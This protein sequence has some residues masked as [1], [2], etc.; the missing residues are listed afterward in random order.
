MTWARVVENEIIEIFEED[1]A[2]Y[3]HPDVL[4]EWVDIPNEGVHVGWKF[5]NGQ[6]ISGGQWYDEFRAE[7]PLPP[8]GPPTVQIEVNHKETRTHDQFE[9]NYMIGG[10]GE[11]VEWNINGVKYTD[12]KVTLELAKTSE[13]F[14]VPASVKVTGPGGTVTK[15][16]EGDQAITVTPVFV[17]LFQSGS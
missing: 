1:P 10:V 11:F 9:F 12:E 4:H 5:K 17:P 6:W 3:F 8:E 7:N 14:Q 13:P 2:K 16:L 15:T